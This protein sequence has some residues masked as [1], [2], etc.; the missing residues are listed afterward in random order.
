MFRHQTLTCFVIHPIILPSIPASFLCLLT[1]KC[2]TNCHIYTIFSTISPTISHHVPIV[3]FLAKG[4]PILCF[5]LHVWS[6]KDTPCI[7][8]L[9]CYYGN[10]TWSYC[11]IITHWRFSPPMNRELLLTDWY[12]LMNRPLSQRFTNL[13]LCPCSLHFGQPGEW[14]PM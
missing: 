4:S 6:M 5:D 2:C 10:Y 8:L 13:C 3:Y 12:S 9:F 11:Y 1:P 14:N 7:L